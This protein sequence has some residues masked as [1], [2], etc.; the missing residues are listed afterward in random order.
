LLGHKPGRVTAEEVTI[1]DSDGLGVQDV[2]C[3]QYVYEKAREQK[4]G[5]Y[6]DFGLADVP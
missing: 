6:I 3:A 5:T 4:L 1:F 2:V